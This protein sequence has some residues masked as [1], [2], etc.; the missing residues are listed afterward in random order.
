MTS[1]K[2]LGNILKGTKYEILKI[3][4]SKSINMKV[5]NVSNMNY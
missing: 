5:K 4:Y 3:K 1:I 2:V